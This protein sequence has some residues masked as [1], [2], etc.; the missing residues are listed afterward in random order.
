M[1]QYRVRTRGSAVE[2]FVHIEEVPGSNPGA[3]TTCLSMPKI[4]KHNR[5]QIDPAKERRLDKLFKKIEEERTVQVCSEECEMYNSGICHPVPGM[6]CE[7]QRI[8]RETSKG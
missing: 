8:S 6:S 5:P 4:H 7:L 2:R 3:S 1:L